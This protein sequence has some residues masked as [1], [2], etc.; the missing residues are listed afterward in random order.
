MDVGLPPRGFVFCCFNNS[1]KIMPSIFDCWMHILKQVNGSVLWL[2][3][4]N[5]F[6]SS[7]LKKEAEA[8]GVAAERLVFAQRMPLSDHLGRH[9]LADLFLDTLPYNAHTTASDAL[10]AGLPMLTCPGETFAGRVSASLLRAIG[11]PELITPTVVDYEQAAVALATCPDK[12]GAIRRRLEDNRLTAPLFDTAL[13]TK[14]LEE[15]Y[16][17]MIQ[18]HRSGFPPDHI[19]V[20]A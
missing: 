19:A 13:F 2:I 4:D 14:H 10:W 17:A 5:P 8:R 20:R 15:A 11:L 9:R 7:N 3:D 1:Y 6:A 16:I 12:L 18:R